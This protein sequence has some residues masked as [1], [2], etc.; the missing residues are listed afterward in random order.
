MKDIENYL[1]KPQIDAMLE[2]ALACNIRDYLLI[3]L[4]WR[5]GIRVDE[6]LHIRPRDL[7][8]H[9]NM[10]RI[11]KA[12]RNK[13]RRVPLDPQ[14]L[15]QLR[16]YINENAID[17]LSPIFPVTRQWARAIVKR[18]GRLIERD[19]HP[20]TFRHSFAIN[21]V[22]QNWDIRRLQ[23]VLGH[24]SMATTAIYLRFNDADIQEIY[25]RTRF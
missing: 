11:V 22:R 5:T 2:A 14:T 17:A 6:L 18:Y 10:V 21:C 23:Q 13:Q 20:H 24:S 25:D 3:I 1:E 9:T 16:E 7:E 8:Y 4:L 19:V 12:K 15:A